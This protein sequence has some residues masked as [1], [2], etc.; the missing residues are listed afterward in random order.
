LYRR[1]GSFSAEAL[2]EYTE[3]VK[4]LQGEHYE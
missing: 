3:L 2:T 1:W 4:H